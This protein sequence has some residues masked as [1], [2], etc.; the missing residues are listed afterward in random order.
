MRIAF[1]LDGVLADLHTP[2]VRVAAKL[3]PELDVA[4]LAAAD[5]GASPPADSG[6]TTDE[7]GEA[8]LPTLPSVTLNRRQSDQVW[9]EIAATSNFWE[10]LGEIEP[11][12]IA[13]LAAIADARGWE[14]LFITSRPRSAGRTVQR[15]SQRW[16]EQCG[17]PLPSLFVVHGSRGRIAEA[18]AIDVVVDD[19]PDN[20]LDIVLE[21]KAGALL[22]WRGDPAQV[23]SSAKR[24]GIAVAPTVES[25]LAALIEAERAADGGPGMLDRLRKLFGL[26]TRTA[27]PLVRS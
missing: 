6:A 17:F 21:S 4:A 1:D 25:V 14:V 13:K 5:L 9:R 15:Q 20:C 16:L 10:T 23:P 19:R 24:L 22:V 8:L 3:F 26:K 27:S 11:G 18:M 12:A 2:F 7:G